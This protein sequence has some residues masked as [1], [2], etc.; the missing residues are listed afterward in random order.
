[1]SSALTH[2]CAQ[3]GILSMYVL[4]KNIFVGFH[5]GPPFSSGYVQSE[6]NW[7]YTWEYCL[8]LLDILINA[9]V[10]GNYQ[11]PCIPIIIT[12]LAKQ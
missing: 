5:Y 3:N 8:H 2:F 9:L 11:A 4:S 6:Q 7:T 10:F 1:M 12:Q